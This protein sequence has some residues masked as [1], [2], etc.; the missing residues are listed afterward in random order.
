MTL[1]RNH[2]YLN[3]WKRV[4]L[5]LGLEA[6]G[7]LK[8]L[9]SAKKQKT[10]AT[11]RKGVQEESRSVPTQPPESDASTTTTSSAFVK[12]GISDNTREQLNEFLQRETVGLNTPCCHM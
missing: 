2:F 6:G 11:K 4:K 5:V 3:V 10:E 9:K 7:L 12:R 1:T 8:K